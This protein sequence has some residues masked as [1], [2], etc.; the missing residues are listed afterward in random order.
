M[1]KKNA[2][3]VMYMIFL[4]S[5]ILAFCAMAIDAT[6]IYNTRM[7]LQDATE[8][9]A[10]A[11]AELFN[12]K[13][14]PTGTLA[15]TIESAAEEKAEEIF[16]HF[17]FGDLKSV[18][19]TIIADAKYSNKKIL[20]KTSAYSPTFFLSFL[21]VQSVKINA[22]AC[23]VSEK[24]DVKSN[25]DSAMWTT[26]KALYR[27]GIIYSE[28]NSTDTSISKPL[29]QISS[30]QNFYSASY[31]TNTPIF[32][33]I[34]DI[35]NH[36]L[37]LGPGG[38]LLIRLPAPI[39]DKPGPDLFIKEAGKALEGY[40]VFAGID[41]DPFNPYLNNATQ[42]GG[43]AW[44]NITCSAISEY[45]DL[46]N[47]LVPYSVSTTH[48]GTQEKFYGSAYFDLG[49]SCIKTSAGNNANL[50]M[51]KYIKIV[52]DNS[53]SAFVK[54]SLGSSLPSSPPYSYYKA[55]LFGEASTATAG[56]DIDAI[57]ILNFV[58]LIPP[59]EHL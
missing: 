27:S 45:E 34:D 12:D 30:I 43:V 35:D 18:N 22:K 40:F 15:A 51:A 25:F 36:P 59:P 2:S 55:M 26:P 6:I 4:F 54:R 32:R 39:V 28:D 56:A 24:M 46:N 53:E 33:L 50:S 41:I 7:K 17:L 16:G 20:V 5:V 9:A 47:N 37:S 42:G 1:K 8:R 52:D 38:Y 21:G 13:F 31:E 57:Q 14:Y 29:G 58:R 23:A 49:D 48:S 19:T 10:L 44:K 3:T 11:G